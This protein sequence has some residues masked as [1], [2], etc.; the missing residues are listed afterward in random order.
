MGPQG[1]MFRLKIKSVCYR[2]CAK[3]KFPAVETVC[4]CLSFRGKTRNL[5]FGA[6]KKGQVEKKMKKKS[7]GSPGLPGVVGFPASKSCNFCNAEGSCG[8]LHTGHVSL[9]CVDLWYK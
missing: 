3:G 5:P 4:H 2:S 8:A 7:V 9:C 6:F 1:L